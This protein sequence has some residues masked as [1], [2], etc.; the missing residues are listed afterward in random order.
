[1]K[2][3]DKGRNMGVIMNNSDKLR[4]SCKSYEELAPG[5]EFPHVSYELSGSIISKYLKA[6]DNPEE[7]KAFGEFVSPLAIAA[8]A[9]TAMAGSL[10]LPP[11]AIHVSQ[12]LEFFKLLPIGATIDCQAK[13]AQMITRGKL[14]MLVLELNVFDQSREIVQSGR[15]TIMLP[16]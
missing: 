5:Y 1:V 2:H 11:G 10:S 13:V 3:K 16:A 12:E 7:I 9:M 8:Y 15:A 14:H 4:Q 6:V